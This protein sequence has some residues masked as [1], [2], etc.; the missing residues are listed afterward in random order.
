MSSAGFVG[1]YV[2]TASPFTLPASFSLASYLIQTISFGA[3]VYPL[4]DYCQSK[5]EKGRPLEV[6]PSSP[7]SH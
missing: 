1:A 6:D 3:V 5:G 4:A 7:Y 2:A